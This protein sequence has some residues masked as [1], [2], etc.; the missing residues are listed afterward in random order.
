MDFKGKQP[1]GNNKKNENDKRQLV[2]VSGP[3]HQVERLHGMRRGRQRSNQGERIKRQHQHHQQKPGGRREFPD[4][5]FWRCGDDGKWKG[6]LGFCQ[7]TQFFIAIFF[8][9]IALI[10]KK[11]KG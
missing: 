6:K 9:L 3:T 5:P 7:G 11:K 10:K 1:N 8:L 2:A 4:Q